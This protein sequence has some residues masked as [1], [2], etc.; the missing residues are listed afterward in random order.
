MG[1]L[2]VQ[3]NQRQQVHHPNHCLETKVQLVR[4]VVVEYHLRT[5]LRKGFGELCDGN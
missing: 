2:H 5:D 3:F 4:A 1:L